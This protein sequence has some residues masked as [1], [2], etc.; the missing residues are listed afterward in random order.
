MSTKEERKEAMNQ[1]KYIKCPNV[2]ICAKKKKIIDH[3]K[4][5]LG[6]W[7]IKWAS[8]QKKENWNEPILAKEH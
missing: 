1:K 2:C 6:D 3:K 7:K 8:P 5:Q 4:E